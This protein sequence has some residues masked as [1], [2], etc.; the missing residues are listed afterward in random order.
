MKKLFRVLFLVV[1][2]ISFAGV[3]HAVPV[4]TNYLQNYSFEDGSF[5]VWAETG[6][7]FKDSGAYSGSFSARLGVAG[8]VVSQ[9]IQHSRSRLEIHSSQAAGGAGSNVAIPVRIPSL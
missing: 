5:D 8:G 7:V 4:A 2:V 1:A 9:T 6:E 3:A